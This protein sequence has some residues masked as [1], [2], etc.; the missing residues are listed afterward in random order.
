MAIAGVLL[1]AQAMRTREYSVPI[2]FCFLAVMAPRRAPS[3][4]VS[5]ALA[6]LLGAGLFFHGRSTL[7]LLASHL[8]THQY[9][10]A[11]RLLEENGS[12][13]ILNIAEADYCMLRW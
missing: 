8:P 13:P 10:G 2:A 7:P 4:V 12:H 6:G 3:R 9:R 11:R 5:F 1:T